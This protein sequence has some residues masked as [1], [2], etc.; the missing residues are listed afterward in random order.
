M[1]ELDYINLNW[2]LPNLD[3]IGQSNLT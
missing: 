1:P 3:K 2:S